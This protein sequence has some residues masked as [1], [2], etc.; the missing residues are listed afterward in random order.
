MQSV[1]DR[2]RTYVI[3]ARARNLKQMRSALFIA[4]LLTVLLWWTQWPSLQPGIIILAVGHL[5]VIG[6]YLRR[7]SAVARE[8]DQFTS[9]PEPAQFATWFR[10]EQSFL[11]SVMIV[12]NGVRA[13]GFAALAYGFWIA[14][15]N[16]SLSLLL[17]LI[18]PV[19][20]YFGI[21]RRSQQ[22]VSAQLRIQEHEVE[23]LLANP[24]KDVA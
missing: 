8:L 5:V 13:L 16:L 1:M 18:Y 7:N 14:T 22:R 20:V 6:L 11:H 12:E 21:A 4:I 3:Q 2:M 23:A 19:I 9:I 10:K 17:G 24:D 15:R